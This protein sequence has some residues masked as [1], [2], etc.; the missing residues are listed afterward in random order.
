MFLFLNS[1]NFG[2]VEY[3]FSVDTQI[4]M[5]MQRELTVLARKHLVF[6]F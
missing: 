2:Y 3:K 5:H 4:I 1:N 6:F